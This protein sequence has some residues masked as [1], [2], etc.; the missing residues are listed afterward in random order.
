MAVGWPS[1][2]D[3]GDLGQLQ[4]AYDN[5]SA[6]DLLTE[7]RRALDVP[8]MRRD[9][10]QFEDLA[11][12]FTR[13]AER[14]AETAHD[15]RGT[16]GGRVPDA[17]VGGT[18]RA[19]GVVITALAGGLTRAEQIMWKAADACTELADVRIRAERLDHD[20][21]DVLAR[22]VEPVRATTGADP[23]TPGLAERVEQL[24][25]AA[26]DAVT[27][28]S[29]ARVEM[30][31]GLDR[32]A[33]ILRNMV[34]QARL[35]KLAPSPLSTVDELVIAHAG[36][37][38]QWGAVLTANL[39]E[40]AASRLAG[41]NGADR[42]TME[43][44]LT[45]AATPHEQA[46]LLKALAVGHDVKTVG[47]FADAIRPYGADPAWL[48]QHLAPLDGT[49]TG[50]AGTGQNAVGTAFGDMLWAQPDNSLLCVP[51]SMILART[52]DPVY[53]LDLTTGG[54][55]GDPALDNSASFGQRLSA[56]ANRLYADARVEI[57]PENGGVNIF[58]TASLA[59]AHVGPSLGVS[60]ELRQAG[61]PADADLMTELTGSLDRGVPVPMQTSGGGADVGH[62]MLAVG[63]DGTRIQIYDPYAGV[64]FWTTVDELAK[65]S[66]DFPL[67]ATPPRLNWLLLPAGT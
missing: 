17:I 36:A 52:G 38:D 30:R 2:G 56:E 4:L 39:A 31:E 10:T 16:A 25:R 67:K 26:E 65:G 14:L 58:Q 37:D 42:A 50:A 46:Y 35:V 21:A 34:G 28:R 9:A 55:P 54:R 45:R 44:L 59:D 1:P 15:A 11:R 43:T 20:G 29:M 63:H 22:L 27:Q 18:G 32:A 66:V 40:R 64:T 13:Y 33:R 3:R 5:I 49:T 51:Y 41:L 7:V 23:A 47:T 8:R 6:G 57:A 12:Q 19:A 61:V 48:D 24:K 53:A 62:M 60:Y